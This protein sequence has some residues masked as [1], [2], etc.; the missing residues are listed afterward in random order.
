MIL[1][2]VE[3]C[4]RAQNSSINS[5]YIIKWILQRPAVDS[6]N[7]LKSCLI[8]V[9]DATGLNWQPPLLLPSAVVLAEDYRPN[10]SWRSP[11]IW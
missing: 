7:Q 5:G 8:Q 2:K 9:A 6:R 10:R 11:A 3:S 4:V 1:A